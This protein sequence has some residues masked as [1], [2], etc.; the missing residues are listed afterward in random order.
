MTLCLAMLMAACILVSCSSEAD[1]TEQPSVPPKVYELTA[2]LVAKDGAGTRSVDA[3]GHTSWEIGEEISLYYVTEKNGWQPGVAT[4]TVVNAD[5]SATINATLNYPPNGEMKLLYPN[6]MALNRFLVNFNRL[7]N[8]QKGTIEDISKRFDVATGT[9]NVTYEGSKIICD[10]VV[11]KNFLCICKFKLSIGTPGDGDSF[12]PSTSEFNKLIISLEDGTEYTITSD[13]T[14][15]GGGTRGFIN[16]DEVYVAMVPMSNTKMRLKVGNGTEHYEAHMGKAT[17]EKGKF[18]RNIPAKLTPGFTGPIVVGDGETFTLDNTV[19]TNEYGP[20][21]IC[22]GDATI[23]LVGNNTLKST[24]SGYPAIQA[25]PEGTTLT[26]TGSGSLEATGANHA[27]GIGAK[28]GQDIYNMSKHGNITIDCSGTVTAESAS[29]GAGIG[30]GLYADCGNITITGSGTV[31]AT[32]GMSGAGIGCGHYGNCGDITINSSGTVT[33]QNGYNFA[34]G[35]GGSGLLRLDAG[36]PTQC[37]NITITMTGSGTLS[38]TSH[39]GG[40]GIG[41]G[42]YCSCGD[43]TISGSGSVK[44]ECPSSGASIGTGSYGTCGAITISCKTTEAKSGSNAAGIGSGQYGKFESIVITQDI[45]TLRARTFNGAEARIGKGNSD[46]GSGSVTVD[47]VTPWSGT[48]TEHLNF[49]QTGW[50]W[51]LTHK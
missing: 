5:K 20:A 14:K 42:S 28:Q 40:A 49:E 11:M 31:T 1:L 44:A 47:G 36:T 13:R 51:V 46:A 22:Q 12:T 4:V 35:I 29:D 23:Q 7:Y 48:E 6:S 8:N 33:A 25:G 27:A 16:G 26:I 30:G 3:D 41:S 21:V 17:L 34:A 24:C 43:I 32:S 45:E 38:A 2:T 15:E 9:A 18:Y 39:A 19:L 10:P 50:W 37:G